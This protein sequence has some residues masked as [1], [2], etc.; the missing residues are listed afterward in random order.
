MFKIKWITNM[1]CTIVD[2][3]IVVKTCFE[4]ELANGDRKFDANDY[5]SYLRSGEYPKQFTFDLSG[6]VRR[7]KA[8]KI[9]N[10]VIFNVTKIEIKDYKSGSNNPFSRIPTVEI[11]GIE[12]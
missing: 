7:M 8:R 11:E 12:A 5:H 1:D 3:K 2:N 6:S 10:G 4:I 9:L